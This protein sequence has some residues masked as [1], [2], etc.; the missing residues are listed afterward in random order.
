MIWLSYA[1]TSVIVGI[2]LICGMAIGHF[3]HEE[4]KPGKKYLELFQAAALAFALFFFFM[5]YLS[6][7]KSAVL[8]AAAMLA[9]GK[10]AKLKKDYIAYLALAAVFYLSS[11]HMAQIVS[12]LIFLYS[13]PTGS[14]LVLR[15]SCTSSIIYLSL[16]F[17]ALANI[18]FLIFH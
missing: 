2:G 8:M 17:I 11:N 9:A 14:L 3:A 1:L 18:L 15:K 12:A 13:L 16:I 10:A 6:I 4:L 7:A 5:Q